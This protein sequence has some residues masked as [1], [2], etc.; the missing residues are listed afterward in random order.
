MFRF[1]LLSL[2]LGV[3]AAPAQTPYDVVIRNGR[4]VDGT[5]NPWF[6]GDVGV[7]GERI[8]TIGRVPAGAAKR[9][10]DAK[11]LVVAPGFIDMHSHSDWVL[12]E[13]GDAQSKIRQGVTTEVLGEGTSA[14]PWKGKLVPHRVAVS[15]RTAMIITLDDYF[16]TV[17]ESRI[18]VNIASYVGI[19]NV[20][21]AVMGQ[22]FERPTAEQLD[23]MKALVREAMADGAFGLS[24][25]VMMPPGS[26]ATTDDIIALCEAVREYGGIYA[27]HVRNE[28]L[29]VFDSI[30]EVIEI[31][32][33]ARIPAD[34]LHLKI[35]DEKYW[36]RMN[37][38]V[39]LIEEARK[40]GVN[41]Q[42]N[43][44]PY[45]RGNNNLSSI[46][47]PWAHEGGRTRMLERLR[48]PAEREKMKRDIKNGLPG[49]YNHYTAVG[50]DWSRMLISDKNKYK[51]QTM[52]QVIAAKSKD[53]NPPP[54]PL[55]VFFDF[56]LE[57]EGSVSTVYAHHTEKD[58]N[59][60]LTQPWCSIGSDGSAYA[61]EGPLRRGYPHPRNFGTFPRVLGVYV[62]EK[63][64]LRLE[65]A[66]RKMTSLNAVKLGLGDR[67]LL[68]E[69]MF[70]DITI[71]DPERVIDRSTYEDPFHYNEGI[72]YVI[73]NGQV[74]LDRGR[75]TGARPG[76]V[77]RHTS[78]N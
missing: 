63:N 20:W 6:Y 26:L 53:K 3:L 22:S 36:G 37:E 25:Q 40:R 28:G 74:V 11:G 5:G 23:K 55:D 46:I 56:L 44:Y 72:D 68:R 45:T 61:I 15:N 2:G 16:K 32:E 78:Q 51:G 43:V 12:I 30:K 65:E 9:E 18:A 21:E 54:A 39:A 41:V 58:M 19:G 77:L 17:E 76:K 4:I 7:R 31:A 73:V 71:F 47:P 57:N 59:L 38:V 13:D 70:G 27:T 75:H 69:G 33:R 1:V 34:I 29:G 64:L 62:R 66:V 14:G 35:A 52:D 48:E 50:G 42:A 67:G 8:A 24:S 60:A 49:W 10:I